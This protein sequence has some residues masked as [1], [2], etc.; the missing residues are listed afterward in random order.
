MYYSS[1][2]LHVYE[3]NM[4][5]LPPPLPALPSLTYCPVVQFTNISLS[6]LWEVFK[7]LISCYTPSFLTTLPCHYF[8]IIVPPPRPCTGMSNIGSATR[9]TPPP[10]AYLKHEHEYP[11]VLNWWISDILFRNKIWTFSSF[12]LLREKI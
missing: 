11:Y 2:R 7:S 9:N 12:L 8:S 10:P 1:K 5:K 6:V 3:Y 4:Y